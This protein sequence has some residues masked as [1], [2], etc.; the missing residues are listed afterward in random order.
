[1]VCTCAYKEPH[2]S[3]VSCC[4]ELQSQAGE[5]PNSIP[6]TKFRFS[7]R[8][9][10]SINCQSL[11]S[12]PVDCGSQ[13]W[14][15]DYKY[16]S[17]F[18]S[19]V[20]PPHTHTHTPPPASLIHPRKQPENPCRFFFFTLPTIW[21]LGWAACLHFHPTHHL[22]AELGRWGLGVCVSIFWYLHGVSDHTNHHYY[23]LSRVRYSVLVQL[24]KT[25]HKM[26]VALLLQSPPPTTA[27]R[28]LSWGSSPDG[29]A[30]EAEAGGSLWVHNQSA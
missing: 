16:T 17:G 22:E 7:G 30:Q 4:L 5:P 3:K 26:V 2:N 18:W 20:F 6:G 27:A 1:V 12:F 21:K 11:S 19:L 28:S 14:P 13:P 29:G 8:T 15:Q 25:L 23:P 9:G 10:S 24:V